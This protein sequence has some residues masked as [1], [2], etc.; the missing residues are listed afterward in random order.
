MPF[1]EN[2]VKR[3]LEKLSV[4][5]LDSDREVLV[6]DLISFYSEILENQND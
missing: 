1:D 3:Q 2:I 6:N 4:N 5:I